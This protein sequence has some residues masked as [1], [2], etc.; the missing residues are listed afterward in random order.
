MQSTN[1]ENPNGRALS[2]RSDPPQRP[3][4][5]DDQRAFV[6]AGGRD[7]RRALRGGRRRRGVLALAGPRRGDRRRAAAP[8]IPG[9][10]DSHLHVIRGGLNYNLE[11]RWDGVPS[12]ADAMR[13][14]ARAGRAHAA[15]PVGA[16]RRRLRASSSSPSGAC[17]RS[18]SSTPRR[19]TR[20]SSS[21]TSTT[22][23]C[24][25][26]RRCAPSATRRTRPTRPAA[27]I[28]RDKAGEPTGLLVANPNA[29]DPLQDARARPEAP[30]RAPGELDAP[31]HARAQ[32]P[33]RDE[34]LRRRRRLPELPR[35]LRG[36][37]G[38]AQARRADGA[39]RLQPLHAEARA[40]SARTSRAGSGRRRSYQGD[41]FLPLN[42]AGEMLVYS[43]AD[44]EDFLVPRPDMPAGMERDLEAVVRCSRATAGRSGCT[45]PT[46]RRSRALSTCSSGSTATC[47]STSLRWFFDHCETI[48]RSQHRARQGARRRHRDPAP[49]G[50]PGRVLH[51]PLRRAGR[52][53]ARRPS[54]GCSRWACPSARAPMRPASRATTRGS[55]SR[56]WSPGKTVGGTALYPE[57][58]RARPRRSAAAVTRSG[59]AWFSR[60]EDEEGHDRAGPVRRS[61]RAERRLLLGPGARDPRHRVAC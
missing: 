11:L 21:C 50:V 30:A 48:T 56:G 59:S 27:I 17:R 36:D 58:N 41:E 55:A 3:D 60:E 42:G 2:C 14:A 32:P 34:R 10:N 20:R 15:R 28:E 53:S 31:L 52:A 8:S 54:G 45:R 49:H 4:R 16:R 51:R 6:R 39:H 46:T 35:R 9:L 61:R 25:T 12:L 44:F 5:D 18:R 57:A 7:P 37:P 43:A 47:R 26:A 1:S 33:R 40:R 22:A 24:S 19:R 23:R 13:H 29:L 38:A